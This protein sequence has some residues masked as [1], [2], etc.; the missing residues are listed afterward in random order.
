MTD[1]GPE[2]AGGTDLVSLPRLEADGAGAGLDQQVHV[3]LAFVMLE[4]GLQLVE[5]AVVP[6]RGVDRQ[7]ERTGRSGG[8]LAPRAISL[9]SGSKRWAS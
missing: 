7:L 8:T 1:S 6:A 4:D 2:A 9:A 3:G 5:Q